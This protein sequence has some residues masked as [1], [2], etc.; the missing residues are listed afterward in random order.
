MTRI[1]PPS[2]LVAEKL[3]EIYFG[4]PAARRATQGLRLWRVAV[5]A[6]AVL[7][8]LMA[9]TWWVARVAWRAQRPTLIVA[10]FDQGMSAVGRSGGVGA[11]LGHPEDRTQNCRIL[12]DS[13]H[14]RG[15]TGGALRIEYDVE[16]DGPA[17]TGVWLTPPMERNRWHGYDTLQFGL[18]ADEQ[19][20]ASSTF[21]VVLR[22]SHH[23]V[24]Y[25]MHGVTPAWREFSVP[26]G[27]LHGEAPQEILWL[28]EDHAV[29]QRAGVVY[30]DDVQLR[31]GRFRRPVVPTRRE[32]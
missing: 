10:D 9:M 7:L 29:T 31:H 4:K 25:E 27:E 17:L 21:A 20:G 3:G 13:A 23:R 15:G 18:R 1:V 16:A 12:W 6:P 8:G 2:E 32:G 5:A 11:W 26:L 14:G 22:S 19:Q 30:L 24:H 28:F